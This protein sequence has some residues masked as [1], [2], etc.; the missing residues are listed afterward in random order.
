MREIRKRPFVKEESR[1][2]A[3]LTRASS[4]SLSRRNINGDTP[5][6][7]IYREAAAKKIDNCIADRIL[8]KIKIIR[9]MAI[10]ESDLHHQKQNATL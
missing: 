3:V 2:S 5:L 9:E 4:V 7:E 8:Y 6:R 10:Y 1:H